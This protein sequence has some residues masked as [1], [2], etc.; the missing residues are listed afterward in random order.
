MSP[1]QASGQHMHCCRQVRWYTTHREITHIISADRI[2]W[3]FA[4]LPDEP[5]DLH[6]ETTLVPD[7]RDHKVSVFYDVLQ[8][9][10]LTSVFHVNFLYSFPQFPLLSSDMSP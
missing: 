3:Q 5:S 2:H 9:S 6:S 4:K 1:R 10:V 7:P 8:P